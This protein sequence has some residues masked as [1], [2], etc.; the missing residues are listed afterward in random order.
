[1][2]CLAH[3][4][5]LIVKE[6]LKDI[7]PSILR[8]REAIRYVRVSTIRQN[9]F[10]GL[11]EKL[12]IDYKGFIFLDCDIRW[13]STYLMLAAALK[14]QKVFEELEIIDSKYVTELSK[15]KDLPTIED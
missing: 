3:V 5:N 12:G 10:K 14:F 9:V 1:M 8:I 4:L 7:D 13:N 2:C 11:V 6:G 15:G